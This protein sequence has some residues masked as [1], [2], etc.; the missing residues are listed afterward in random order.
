VAGYL[1]EPV[2][3]GARIT[4]FGTVRLGTKVSMQMRKNIA[5]TAAKILPKL[6]QHHNDQ[7]RK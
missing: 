6:K 1:I 5:K 3:H 7:R 2:A 4:R